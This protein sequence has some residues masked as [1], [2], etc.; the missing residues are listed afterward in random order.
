LVLSEKGGG[1]YPFFYRGI[2]HDRMGYPKKAKRDV[3]PPFFNPA[4]PVDICR[5]R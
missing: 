5:R 2:S 3:L 1:G 4:A